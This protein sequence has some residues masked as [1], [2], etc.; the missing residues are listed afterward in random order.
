MIQLPPPLL[1][2]MNFLNSGNLAGAESA[3][4]AFLQRQSK[5]PLASNLLAMV[6]FKQN[7]LAEA[8]FF[9]KQAVDLE[10]SNPD[11]RNGLGVVLVHHGRHERA[12]EIFSELAAEYPTRPAIE[13][14]LG[15]ALMQVGRHHEAQAAFERAFRLDPGH[16]ETLRRYGVL[17]VLGGRV[18]RAQPMLWRAWAAAPTDPGLG[19]TCANLTNY[20]PDCP[21]QFIRETH[22][23]AAKALAPERPAA[24]PVPATPRHADR[25][26]RIGLLSPDL[27]DHSVTQFLSP[28]VQHHDREKFPIVCYHAGTVNDQVSEQLKT[29]SA[30]WGDVSKLTDEQLAARIRS[31]NIDI[32]IDLA[33]LTRNSRVFVATL[34]PAPIVATYLG[35]PSTTGIKSV[36]ERIVDHITDPVGG[37]GEAALTEAPRRID[38]CFLCYSP[39]AVAPPPA[40]LPEG[41]PVFVSFNQAKKL[42]PAVADLWTAILRE[43]PDSRL[44]VRVFGEDP[45]WIRANLK[46]LFSG[47]DVSLDRIELS[48]YAPDRRTHLAEYHRASVALDPFPY[49]GTTTTCEALHMGVPVVTLPGI[50]HAS[51]V[52]ASLLTACGLQELIARDPQ[53]YVRLAVSLA[54]DRARLAEYRSTLRDRLAASSLSDGP[55]FARRFEAC[56]TRMWAERIGSDAAKPPTQ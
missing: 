25:P 13:S 33:G 30:G 41:P 54:T 56:L 5:N 51:R 37:P 6:L 14:N 7:R 35:Y 26:L 17:L 23:R 55:G 47:R 27:H 1:N 50:V 38:G 40:P 53:D 44:V 12:V 10:P 4:R 2:A 31:D 8:E 22:E 15:N 32:L 43:V 9:A 28:L 34:R 24:S 42:N 3:L 52:G 20:L 21:P 36:H 11:Y 39:P 49:A 46:D 45:S 16:I 29:W 19:W 48:D 18:D